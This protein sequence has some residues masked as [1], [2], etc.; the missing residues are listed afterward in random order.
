MIKSFYTIG[1]VLSQDENYAEYFEPWANPFPK[2]KGDE[3]KVIFA[4]IENGVLVDE[5][6]EE[7]FSKK[8]VD[9]YLYRKVQGANGTN[10]V[11]TL[12]LQMESNFDKYADN[13]RK[14]IKKVKQSVLNNK[15]TFI[16]VSC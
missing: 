1:K 16:N 4:Q 11:P 10:L 9:S 7:I 5:L 13:V 15:H 6:T 12:L 8:R 3:A 14:L 2:V